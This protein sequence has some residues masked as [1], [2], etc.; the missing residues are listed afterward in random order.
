MRRREI[1]KKVAVIALAI[2]AVAVMLGFLLPGETGAR[3]NRDTASRSEITNQPLVSGSSSTGK[4]PASFA[5]TAAEYQLDG[6][7]KRNELGQ[8]LPFRER[9]FP[10]SS[11]DL[12]QRAN[13]GNFATLELFPGVSFRVRVTGSWDDQDGI[14]VAA[15][16]EGR[17]EKDRLFASWNKDSMRA[18]IELPSENL[19]YELIDDGKGGYLVREWLFTDVVCA[20]PMPQTGGAESGIPRPEQKTAMS[21]PALIEP[22]QVPQ[23]S[24]RP[25]ATAVIYLDFDGE[26]V[27]SSAWNGGQTIVAQP[28]RMNASQ[29]EET[30][31]RIVRDFETFDVNVTTVRATYDGAPMAR[32]TQ[33][34]VTQNDA[35]APGAGGV[36][37]IGRFDDADP[38]YKV[39]WVF[40]DND[41]KS[42]AEAASHE[43]GHM[44]GLGHD[45]RV[46]SGTAA[47]EEYYG[48]HGTGPTGWAPIMGVGYDRQLTQWSKGEYARA[49][50]TQDDLLIMT[51][52]TRAPYLTDD[53]GNSSGS[54]TAV[55]GDRV[56]GRI[57]RNT[58]SDFFSV[59]LAAGTYTV[60]A[61]PDSYT[62]LDIDL[63]ILNNSG[64]VLV[65]ANPLDQLNASAVLTIA[66]PQT[67]FLRVAGAG[68]GDLLGTGYSNYASLGTYSITGFGDQQQPP[69]API[70]LSL[71]RISGT[72]MRLAWTPNPSAT[73]YAI[74][75]NGAFV[76]SSLNTEFTDIGL[77]PSTTYS[78]SVVASNTYGS[79]AASAATVLVTAAFDE[80]VMDGN[81]DFAGYLV[82]NPGMTIYAAVRGTKLYVATWSPGDNNSGAGS[83][84][85]I[86]ISDSLLPSAA[87]AAPWSKRGLVAIASNKPYLAGESSST[88][89]GWF[90]TTG[91]KTLFK[92]PLNSGVLE[93]SI[94]LVSEFG[95]LPDNVYI[96]AIAYQTE[97][98]TLADAT[99]G[100]INS[101]APVGNG[102]D[103]LEPEEFF[104]VPV[105]SARDAA[106]NGTYDILDAARSF[107][108]T[109]VS[110]NASNQTVLRWPVVPGKNYMVQGR[111]V[112][113]SGAWT[114][115]L[116]TNWGAGPTQWE[117]EFT[118]LTAPGAA[119][120]Y[121]VTQP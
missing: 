6:P 35:A 86:F 71:S 47:R 40:L 62:D 65:A 100:K 15:S 68:K 21:A 38:A 90:N 46:A 88:Y 52:A 25:G 41:A 95:T 39:C 22:G 116:N 12:L 4:N 7:R 79:S 30:W 55:V 42:C 59:S 36:A 58:D 54:S 17:P 60:I 64:G 74:Y 120:Y 84:H 110:F 119:K 16:L 20:T 43:V 118:D 14:R 13:R 80:F 44:L 45:G 114:N 66:S 109:N 105:R 31:R 106:Q 94:D 92:A 101:Q 78:Y 11:I 9:A 50:N 111:G 48:G 82:S 83:D 51:I 93:G 56:T 2:A 75:R 70:G 73:S 112:L 28:A 96:A 8:A 103:N 19:A 34:V 102:N 85:H 91:A 117:M 104:R 121:R 69:S 10:V 24:S 77:S 89:A 3:K 37:Y 76:G 67:V 72:Q 27:T 32:K 29:I 1:L 87:T 115:L 5:P 18:L 49:N 53:V 26:T 63:Q 81:A 107:A 23:L 98:A 57:E 99:K 108:V 61:Q 97:D 113:S 33:C